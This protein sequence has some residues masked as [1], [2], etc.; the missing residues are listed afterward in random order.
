MARGGLIERALGLGIHDAESL[1][2]KVLKSRL[3]A[4]ERAAL[5]GGEARAGKR[6]AARVA[7]GAAGTSSGARTVSLAGFGRPA[8]FAPRGM[9]ARAIPAELRSGAAH[10]ASPLAGRGTTLSELVARGGGPV[11]AIP[12]AVRRGGVAPAPI[13]RAASATATTA[14]RTPRR[15]SWIRQHPAKAAAFGALGISALG[16]A[17][18]QG[19]GVTGNGYMPTGS[20]SGGRQF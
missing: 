2:N 18:N 6:T 19:P 17:R 11:N 5:R 9:G 13:T 3:R 20:S 4:A 16:L 14:K 10:M 15:P 8:T 12:E 1:S 7:R